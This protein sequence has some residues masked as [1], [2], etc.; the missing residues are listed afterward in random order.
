MTLESDPDI[1]FL[2]QNRQSQAHQVL[3]RC[4]DGVFSE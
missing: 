1:P 4:I 3:S 2:R